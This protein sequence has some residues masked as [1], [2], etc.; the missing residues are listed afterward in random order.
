MHPPEMEYFASFRTVWVGELAHISYMN[1]KTSFSQLAVIVCDTSHSSVIIQFLF[2]TGI[3]RLKKY[4][5]IV[6]SEPH[7]SMQ[8]VPGFSSLPEYLLKQIFLHYISPE[9]VLTCMRVCKGWYNL[10]A[11]GMLF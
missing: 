6:R 10:L 4:K 2:F 7:C 5:L 9:E 3:S 8:H 11:Q 1:P